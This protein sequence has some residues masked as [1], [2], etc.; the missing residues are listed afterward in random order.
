[1]KK[2]L[3]FLLF[4]FE[5]AVCKASDIDTIFISNENFSDFLENY[6]STTYP[7]S[8]YYKVTED[9]DTPWTKVLGGSYDYS[10]N[11][12]DRDFTG[13]FDGNGHTIDMSRTTTLSG[14]F[15]ATASGS[16]IRNLRLTGT[17]TTDGGKCQA[18]VALHNN[19]TV[20]NIVVYGEL[21][22]S[23]HTPAGIV[24][25]NSGTVKNCA[26]RGFVQGCGECYCSN[27]YGG[28]IGQNDGKLENSIYIGHLYENLELTDA[29]IGGALAGMNSTTDIISSF[30]NYDSCYH[31]IGENFA[32]LDPDTPTDGSHA[33]GENIDSLSSLGFYLR[34]D[35]DISDDPYGNSIWYLEDG[36]GYPHLR[37]EM[38][39]PVILT[40]ADGG[41]ASAEPGQNMFVKGDTVTL[42]C[43]TDFGY[44]LKGWIVDGD[45]IESSEELLIS[46]I[47][48]IT[49]SPLITP[50]PYLTVSGYSVNFAASDNE[51]SSIS[52][53]T[54][55]SW[56]VSCDSEWIS[57]FQSTTENNGTISVSV[58]DNAE[59]SSRTGTITISGTDV[60]SKTITVTQYAGDPDF[61]ISSDSI[62]VS[63]SATETTVDIFANAAWTASST[64]SWL[65]VSPESGTGD[66]SV[67]VNSD[68]N[69]D[70]TARTAYII[71]SMDGADD[72]TIT[73]NQQ[74]AAPFIETS[75]LYLT[76]G[77]AENSSVELLVYSNISWTVSCSESWFAPSITS[78][79]GNCSIKIV[80]DENP[81]S[82]VHTAYITISADGLDDIT[83]SVTQEAADPEF[84]VSRNSLTAAA[85][86]EIITINITA[87]S[88][89]TLA[90]DDDWLTV[91][92]LSGSGDTVI[93][94]TVAEN[95]SISGRTG[96]IT[97]SMDDADDQVITITQQSVGTG[98]QSATQAS[99][100]L[101]P[102]PAAEY[103]SVHSSSAIE[104]ILFF[105]TTGRLYKSA[106]NNNKID[107][108]NFTPGIYYI[109]IYTE[110]KTVCKKIVIEK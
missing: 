49:V 82:E 61:S 55:V 56:T 17:I 41:E 31:A 46:V 84:T 71:I 90:A 62:T 23:D 37:F 38:A 97:V 26:F 63:A 1:M 40:Q 24:S 87:N 100:S 54:N 28:M 104:K 98:I 66:V 67:T 85:T 81:L 92:P 18:F 86:G 12:S 36:T 35:W 15:V 69:E 58:S 33:A 51:S 6:G 13:T 73:V 109:Q 74:G 14:M 75:T 106:V 78:G 91:S 22:G 16:T 47:K 83:V 57:V 11:T 103:I 30:Y 42:S 60:S 43:N 70:T 68:E 77:A 108:N 110:D 7:D 4:I 94:I 99:I 53:T 34:S 10:T 95:N 80:A 102:N 27:W 93:T 88:Q 59:T 39:G 52:V 105:D 79:T 8:G 19:G 48:E 2:I 9:I 25:E 44:E 101:Y 21:Q 3:A 45:T 65:S 50:L 5:L 107:L 20:E 29:D 89:W 76:V 72:D 32:S 96:E 64:A